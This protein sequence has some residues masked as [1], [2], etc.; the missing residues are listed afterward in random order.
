M[1]SDSRCLDN[2]ASKSMNE[3]HETLA[4]EVMG[5]LTYAM[6]TKTISESTPTP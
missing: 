6:M 3:W 4:Q 1:K 5:T 2:D